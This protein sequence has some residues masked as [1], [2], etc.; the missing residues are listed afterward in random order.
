M[1]SGRRASYN[2]VSTVEFLKNL[3]RLEA[4][5]NQSIVRSIEDLS[6]EPFLGKP[7]R[8][9]LKG[10]YTLRIGEYRVIYSID[11]EKQEVILHA[12]KPRSTVYQG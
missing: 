8:G 9:R 4:L 3:E 1:S 11:I 10:L 5:T 2:L 12:A 6:R 7:L